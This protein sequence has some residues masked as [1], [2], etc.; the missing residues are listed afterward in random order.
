MKFSFG[1]Y[2]KNSG[3]QKISLKLDKWDTVNM[4]YTLALIIHPMLVQL[5][6]TQHG[7]PNVDDE[8]VPEKLRS[9]KAKPKKNEWDTDSN[10]FKRWEWVMDEMIW[11]FGELAKTEEPD[12]W[13]KE[14]KWNT[15]KNKDGNYESLFVSG[16]YNHKKA[17][18]YRSR[19]NNALR[20]FGKYYRGL[21]D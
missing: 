21:W 11:A 3:K 16:K 2:P 9:T 17:E 4:D 19:Q 6:K 10:H 5:K 14:P 15:K 18:A 13:I 7:A 20:L 1:R 12:F 8:D